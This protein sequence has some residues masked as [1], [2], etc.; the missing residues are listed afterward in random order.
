MIKKINE[1][2]VVL[3]NLD[4][5]QKLDTDVL[6]D[7]NTLRY[8]KKDINDVEKEKIKHLNVLY[9]DDDSDVLDS[10]SSMHRFDFNIFTTTDP[11]EAKNIIATNEIHVII[12]DQKMPYMTG[13]EFFTLI[14]SE[15]PEPVRII[16]T[17][18]VSSNT[19]ANAIKSGV[20]YCQITKPF[21]P[22]QMRHTIKNAAEIYYSKKK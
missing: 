15:Y 20:V 21:T 18:Y 7:L 2:S 3:E 4:E 19:I 17:G 10:Y 12:T 6:D 16:L 22:K 13:L 5:K 11:F 1:S 9:L 8:D 14:S